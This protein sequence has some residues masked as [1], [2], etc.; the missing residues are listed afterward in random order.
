MSATGRAPLSHS[1]AHAP[2]TSSDQECNDRS[3]ATG[4]H[5][6]DTG[7]GRAT[8]APSGA[9]ARRGLGHT[10]PVAPAGL[11]SRPRRAPSRGRARRRRRVGTSAGERAATQVRLGG[12]TGPQNFKAW[13]A[14]PTSRGVGLH[15]SYGNSC[16]RRPE[17]PGAA[18]ARAHPCAQARVQYPPIHLSRI[19]R[20]SLDRRLAAAAETPEPEHV[21]SPALRGLPSSG[22]WHRARPACRHTDTHICAYVRPVRRAQGV[23]ATISS[24]SW[25]AAG[26][27]HARIT[28][29]SLSMALRRA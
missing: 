1:D 10:A 28:R 18:R 8:T 11:I 12:A 14:A 19:G 29:A 6:A 27:A 9:R 17:R 13:S 16:L 26:C 22:C 15:T 5:R 20:A 2:A 25:V 24:K 3:A 4:Q 21:K 7:R 23:L